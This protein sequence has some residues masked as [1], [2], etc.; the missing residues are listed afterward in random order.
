LGEATS[1]ELESTLSCRVSDPPH[2]VQIEYGLSF[3]LGR[4]LPRSGWWEL[5]G[6]SRLA[7]ATTWRAI[8]HG[9]QIAA[10]FLLI[11]PF[12]F[13]AARRWIDPKLIFHKLVIEL[14]HSNPHQSNPV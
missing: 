1:S 8:A 2:A 13:I 3:Q 4:Y 11:R 12:S 7:S 5:D 10:L 14:F 9:L 6:A